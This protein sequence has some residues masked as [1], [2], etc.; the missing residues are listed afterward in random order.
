M[1][2]SLT[3]LGSGVN[4]AAAN[5]AIGAAFGFSKMA[6]RAIQLS[7]RFRQG[8]FASRPDMLR[9][10]PM[11]KRHS[12]PVAARP[13][14]AFVTFHQRRSAGL[15]VRPYF[16]RFS[17]D[18]LDL[19]DALGSFSPG[20]RVKLD[21]ISKILS[22]SGKP[23]GVDGVAVAL[24]RAAEG[25]KLVAVLRSTQ[26][27]RSPGH[28]P[29]PHSRRCRAE[30]CPAIA[31]N[32]AAVMAIWIIGRTL[33][34]QLPIDGLAGVM[35]AGRARLLAVGERLKQISQFRIAMLFHEPRHIVAPAPAAR[36]ADDR[37]GR[38]TDV[39]QDERAVARHSVKRI[40]NARLIGA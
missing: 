15:Q 23:E 29:R 24:A 36:L 3:S 26:T 9:R 39:G 11:L 34:Q 40:T 20:A 13:A 12:S 17:D 31:S 28:W 6:N 10:L 5:A 19:C 4:P 32:A 33:H 22:L 37:Q 2:V 27:R 35:N 8:R 14:A 25:G 7:E 16:H 21:E 38:P 1:I 30:G 18:A